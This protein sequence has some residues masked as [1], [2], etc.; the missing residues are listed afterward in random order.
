MHFE[1]L[2]D[3]A[4][5]FRTE[6]EVSAASVRRAGR[7]AER[8]RMNPLPGITDVWAAYTTVTI[9]FDAAKLSLDRTL[10]GLRQWIDSAELAVDDLDAVT[11]S[12]FQCG[13]AA[14]KRRIWQRLR[15]RRA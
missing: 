6:N 2:G 15:I 8:L 4:I 1:A 9:A 13:T 11:S 5:C 14:L 12:R 3:S 7:L 10:V